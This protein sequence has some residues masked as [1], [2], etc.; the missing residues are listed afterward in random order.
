MGGKKLSYL[1]IV[2]VFVSSVNL[3]AAFA[4]PLWQ[5]G[6]EDQSYSEFKTVE[7]GAFETQSI[8]SFGN[9]DINSS[10]LNSGYYDAGYLY[11]QNPFPQYSSVTT[12]TVEALTFNFTLVDDYTQL[13]LSYGRFGSEIDYIFFDGVEMFSVDGTA[14]NEYDLFDLTI[15][16]DISAGDHE[17]TLAYGGGDA[18]NGHYI[19]F[20]RLE[21]G[22]LA[23][24]SENGSP[25]P[26]PEPGTIFLIGTGLFGIAGLG[27]K[28]INR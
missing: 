7:G 5:Y 11:T 17:L 4:L 13:D 24:N 15:I 28:R 23:D 6:L 16:G 19:D 1:A 22:M 10:A 21:N 27:R 2:A 25:A 3:S 20:F 12:A 14:E 8:V 9:V 26:V 18:A